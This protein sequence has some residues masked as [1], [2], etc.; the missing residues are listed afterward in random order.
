MSTPVPEMACTQVLAGPRIAFCGTQQTAEPHGYHRYLWIPKTCLLNFLRQPV[1]HCSILATSPHLT[2]I[3]LWHTAIDALHR[4]EALGKGFMMLPD[5]SCVQC[6]VMFCP[7]PV[8]L[9]SLVF[10]LHFL[11]GHPG[12]HA[13]PRRMLICLSADFQEHFQPQIEHSPLQYLSSFE[14][15]HGSTIQSNLLI[16]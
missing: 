9:I 10:F 4:I 2:L 7:F 13:D 3:P 12:P 5:A 15:L 14:L 6:F 8:L 11:Q 1:P 16:L